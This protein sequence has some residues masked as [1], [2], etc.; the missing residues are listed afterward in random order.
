MI[1][2]WVD[3]LRW[4]IGEP[5]CLEAFKADTRSQW[6][7]PRTALDRM[8]DEA[9]GAQEAFIRQFVDWFNAN[10]WGSMK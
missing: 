6:I 9:T 4:A 1:Q 10:V 2:A 8:I 5:E 7:P 3:C